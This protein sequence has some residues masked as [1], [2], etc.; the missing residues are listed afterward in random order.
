MASYFSLQ[1]KYLKL[2]AWK[3][4]EPFFNVQ[5]IFVFDLALA[6]QLSASNHSLPPEIAVRILLKPYESELDEIFNF[7]AQAGL[8]RRTAAGRLKRGD[9]LAVAT[10]KKTMA[11]YTWAT[12]S[13]AWIAEARRFL[14]LRDDQA[15]QFDTLVMPSWRGKGLHYAITVPVLQCLAKLGYKQ[16][17]TWVN[18][19]NIRSTRT[20]L[21]LGK[22]RIAAIESSPILGMSRLRKLSRDADFTIE[23]KIASS[24]DIR[25]TPVASNGRNY[26]I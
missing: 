4:L 12:F 10:V 5:H 18:V 3:L 21:S 6:S 13:R 24:F 9:L 14:P 1:N 20:Q 16:T 7:L 19:R 25:R 11:A 26:Q 8:P 15:V 22:R 17:L 23:R 2:A